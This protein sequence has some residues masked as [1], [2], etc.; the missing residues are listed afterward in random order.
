MII[1]FRFSSFFIVI[2]GLAGICLACSFFNR[3][4]NGGQK[5]SNDS[6][7]QVVSQNANSRLNS[8]SSETEISNANLQNNS[9][10]FPTDSE[11]S[12]SSD[13]LT[14]TPQGGERKLIL[15][16]LR[17]YVRK[18]YNLKVIFK[19]HWLKQSG[20][21]AYVET[22]PMSPDG[23]QSYEPMDVLMTKGN[24]RWIVAAERDQ[25]VGTSESIRQLRKDFPDAPASIFP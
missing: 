20:N 2:F 21:W 17:D 24:E 1:S 10:I 19:V 13:D 4:N 12:Q 25:S 9:K 8:S 14:E 22:N 6:S 5:I 15:D 11:T 3:Q 7:P 18:N 23:K 16:S